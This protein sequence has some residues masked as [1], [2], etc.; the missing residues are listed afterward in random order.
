VVIVCNSVILCLCCW[1]DSF[2]VLVMMNSVMNRVSL[3]NVV[4]MGISVMWVCWSLGCLV[5]LCV[6]LVSICVLLVMVFGLGSVVF[7]V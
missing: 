7:L 1:I 4:V 6:L 2:M 3:V 5:L